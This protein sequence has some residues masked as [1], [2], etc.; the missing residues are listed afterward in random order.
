LGDETGEE[1]LFVALVT[2]VTARRN[3]EEALR[4]S[5]GRL[6]AIFST[7]DEGYCLC[8]MIA[9]GDGRPVDYRFLEVNPLFEQMT[10]M[11]GAEG[12]TARECVPGLEP[13]WVETY[14]RVGFGRET[15]RFESGSDAMGRWFDIFAAPVEPH[16]RFALVFK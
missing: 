4:A 1:I 9:D 2:D 10:G 14:A 16:G 5:E 15:L 6:R 11:A 7:I 12:R 3:A 8:D 13:H